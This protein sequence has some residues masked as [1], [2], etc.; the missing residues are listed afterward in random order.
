MEDLEVMM[1]ITLMR[2]QN[3][4]QA[5]PTFTGRTLPEVWSLLLCLTTRIEKDA[6][7]PENTEIV[8]SQAGPHRPDKEETRITFLASYWNATGIYGFVNIVWVG[9]GVLIQ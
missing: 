9:E 6:C 5:M 7:L 3:T 2:G 1:T 4:F 8:A